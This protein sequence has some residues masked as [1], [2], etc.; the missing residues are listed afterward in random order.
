METEAERVE[1]LKKAIEEAQASAD[2][3]KWM[4]KR[5][6]LVTAYMNIGSA[7]L[8]SLDFMSAHKYF[9][10]ANEVISESLERGRMLLDS[11]EETKDEALKQGKILIKEGLESME[12]GLNLSKGFSNFCLGM[13][14]KLNRNPGG[15]IEN[16][17]EAKKGFDIAYQKTDDGR[18][19]YLSDYSNA[20]QIFSKASED[21]IRGN[22]SNAK[23]SFQRAKISFENILEELPDYF[24]EAQEKEELQ[25]IQSA[26]KNDCANCETSYYLADAKDLF[27][28]GNFPIAIKQ[29]DKLCEIYSE[30]ITAYSD[31]LPKPAQNLQKGDY[32]N[33]SG[34]K[35]LA[36]GELFREQEKYDRALE[37]YGKARSE[38][39]KAATLYLKS[40]IPQA[41]AMQE[42]MINLF[43]ITEIHIRE[44]KK[45]RKLTNKIKTLENEMNALVKSLAKSGFEVHNIQEMKST[46]EQNVQV[47]QSIENG[48]RRDIEKL[49][50]QLD[51]LPIEE[52]KKDEIKDKAIEV[53]NSTEHG[54]KFLERAKRFYKDA[55]ETLRNLGEKA[56]PILPFVTAALSLLQKIV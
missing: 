41:N 39:E 35:Y 7:C 11:L 55:S 21:L 26:V 12:T 38:W 5:A 40:G 30:I 23:S 19:R 50:E 49:V 6:E 4:A 46:V 18:Y 37:S 53:I 20:L 9:V 52:N 2:I 29:Y 45:E 36:E 33:S 34:F 27:N 22:F 24:K 31:S 1:E 56:K 54:Q 10:L 43:P 8:G 13:A 16:F 48:V 14:N 44:C 28:K 42:T 32:H 47:I 15:A 51:E 25:R 3:D 17:V